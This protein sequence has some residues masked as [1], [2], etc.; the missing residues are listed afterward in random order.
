MPGPFWLPE[1]VRDGDHIEIGMMGAYGVAM[2]GR[3]NGFGD[4]ESVLVDDA[5]M[6]SMYGLAP[7]SLPTPR[8][9]ANVVTS[10]AK[11]R[12]TKGKRRK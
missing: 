5:P 9:E 1:D 2:A 7:R 11:A 3:F 6:A 10:L 8:Q 12:R 4:T